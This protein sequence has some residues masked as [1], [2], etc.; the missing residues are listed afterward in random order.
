MALSQPVE[1]YLAAIYR[2][3]HKGGQATT[4]EIARRLNVSAAST[5][6]MFQRLAQEGLVRYKEYSGVSLT[7]AGEVAALDV[8]RRH[9]LAERF[10]TDVLEIP[11]DRVDALAN[12]MEHALPAEVIQG[13]DRI[14]DNP[15][16]CPHGY[17][18]PDA[19]GQVALLSDRTLAEAAE[20]DELTVSRVDEDDP[21][22]LR[23]LAE[24]GLTPGQRVRVMRKPPF[25][26]P[27]VLDV[28]G[29]ERTV[30]SR[31]AQSVYV[32]TPGDEGEEAGRA[33]A[34]GG[35]GGA[36]GPSD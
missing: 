34:E 35:G 12:R 8:I 32:C 18:I 14:L 21:A 13:F 17:P 3:V 23:Y 9:R 33:A 22:L 19:H 6:H 36:A 1:D 15:R 20:G 7:E 27:L 24:A 30:G 2:A 31:I 5:T 10:L 16:T 29:Q 4:S 28:G 25:E 11:W 26:E